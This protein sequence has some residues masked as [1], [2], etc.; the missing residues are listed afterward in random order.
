MLSKVHNY[1]EAYYWI[2]K[3]VIYTNKW[4]RKFKN[5]VKLPYKGQLGIRNFFLGM[6]VVLFQRF[7]LLHIYLSIVKLHNKCI[8]ILNS[9]MNQQ[10]YSFISFSRVASYKTVHTEFLKKADKL[11]ILT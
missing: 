3:S 2:G 4:I 10:R 9:K 6:E 11:I 5:T 1:T 7:P 8:S